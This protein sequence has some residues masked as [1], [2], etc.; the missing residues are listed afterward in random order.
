MTQPGQN[1]KTKIILTR[2]D[3]IYLLL[4]FAS[5]CLTVWAI[6][7]YNLTIIDIKYL[8][9]AAA[10]G[11][12]I[13]FALILLL[14][15]SSYRVIWTFIIS[16][17]IGGGFSCFG[18]LFL[19]KLF[20]GSPQTKE[21]EIVST[22][23]LGRVSNGNC[24]KPYAVIDFDGIQKQLVFTCEDEKAIKSYHKVAV[25]F[26]KGLFGFGVIRSKQLAQ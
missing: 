2:R 22:G 11:G 13:V 21:F 4:I 5:L 26:S 23:H 10:V 17:A 19:N 3:K 8:F 20:A 18:L 7:I 25:T 16:I 24:F 1:P 9:A 6:A 12:I 15:K 14:H